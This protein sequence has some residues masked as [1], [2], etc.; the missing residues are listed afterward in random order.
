MTYHIDNSHL[1][2]GPNVRHALIQPEATTQATIT[3]RTVIL[4][5][6]AGPRKTFW[7]DLVRFMTRADVVLE[8][9]FLVEMDGLIV[10]TM[11]TNRRA[12]CNYKANPFAWS[13]ETQDEGSA[14]LATTGWTLAQVDSIAWIC[15]A[16]GAKYGTLDYSPCATWLDNGIGYHS[17]FK[18]WSSYTGKTCPGAARIRQMDG[19]RQAAAYRHT[20][21][22]GC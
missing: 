19:V 17:Q 10:Q 7:S 2:Q 4:H 20:L 18:E 14:T 5:S 13:V 1:L 6:Q 15:A 9:H 8:A 16:L 3:G 11:P 21:I 12:D 22:C